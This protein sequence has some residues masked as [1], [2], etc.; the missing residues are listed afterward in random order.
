[1][2]ALRFLIALLKPFPGMVLLSVLLGTATITANIGLM[3]TSAYLIARAAEHPSIAYLQVAIVGVRFFGL[4]RG[5]F[6][7]LERL[8]S[9]S[10]NFKLLANLR[11]WIFTR[12]E[13]LAPGGLL[14]RMGGDLL[15]TMIED[16][17]IL[18]NFYIRAVSPSLVA[19]LILGG[20]SL[21]VGQFSPEIGMILFLGL[22]LSGI[23][24][25][26]V[27]YLVTRS[28]GRKIV[29]LKAEMNAAMIE[30]LQGIEDLLVYGQTDDFIRHFDELSNELG[31]HQM[32][33]AAAS[34]L[35]GGTN[36]VVTHLTLWT[37][38]YYAIPLVRAGRLDGVMMAAIALMILACFEA[39][40]PMAAA[41]QNLENSLASTRRILNTTEIT[42]PVTD[43]IHTM[44]N[45]GN[46]FQMDLHGVWFRYSRED[47][48]VLKNINLSLEPGKRIAL[49]GPSGAGKTSIV[50][51]ILRFYA[52]EHGSILLNGVDVQNIGQDT[53]RQRIAMVAQSVYLFNQSIRNNLRLANPQ[54]N[55]DELREVIHRVGMDNWLA[56]QP[57]GLDTLLGEQGAFMSGGERQRL[58]LARALLQK[59]D[60]IIFDEPTANLDAINAQA[61]LPSL[62]NPIEGKGVL[63]ITHHLVGLEKMDEILVLENGC[64]V[65]SGSHE[66]LIQNE[67]AYF[68]MWKI[69]HE[70]I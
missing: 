14:D 25:P 34:G 9:H 1:M 12:I 60:L 66:Q 30:N 65:E 26:L 42:P 11:V 63:W 29:L 44:D 62:L 16:V 40:T 61:L 57:E 15:E 36:L 7:Y 58:T 46:S 64:I 8:V 54:C 17:E 49:V 70:L 35:S 39:T 3:G 52:Y 50:Q 45:I 22:S 43:A 32:F 37:A 6:R 28:T 5:L 4:M 2:K 13:P 21:F 20:A 41:A 55:D 33:Q 24:V 59:A 27:T 69:Q 47:D 51:L 10:L 38:L 68:R 19:L 31:R 23:G 67:G 53:L 48:W 18:E 56:Q